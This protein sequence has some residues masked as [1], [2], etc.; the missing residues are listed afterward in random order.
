MKAQEQDRNKFSAHLVFLIRCSFFYLAYYLVLPVLFFSHLK[1]FLGKNKNFWIAISGNI[2]ILPLAP[3]FLKLCVYYMK[4]RNRI[5][6]QK[7]KKKWYGEKGS[8]HV[9]V[10]SSKAMT[11]TCRA[12]LGAQNLFTVS[13][14]QHGFKPLSQHPMPPTICINRKLDQK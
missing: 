6:W 12:K 3:D 8:S 2:N 10:N 1:S 5:E 14:R 7:L 9:L 13:G 11:G 4:C